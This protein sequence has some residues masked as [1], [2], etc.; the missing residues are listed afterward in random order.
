MS[1]DHPTPADD[2]RPTIHHRTLPPFLAAC[3]RQ[4][5]PYTPVWFMRQAGRY[6]PEYRTLRERY[7][8]LELMRHPDLATHI[9]LLPRALG[10]DALI[11][12]ADILLPL[13]ALGLHLR[14]EPG[15]GPI[16]EP[17]L[18]PDRV[19]TLPQI[20]VHEVLGFVFQTV[21][22]VREAAPEVPLIGFAGAPFTVASY[23]IEGGSSRHYVHT[24]SWMYRH[25]EAWHHLMT[26]LVEVTTTYLRAQVEAGAQAVQIFDSWAGALSPFD[27]RRYVLPYVQ[28]LLQ[29]LADMGVPRIYFSTGTAGLLPLWQ[30]LDAEVIGVDWRV[31]LGTAWDMVGH[32]HAIQGNL[33]PVALFAPREELARQ[34]DQVL[35]QVAGRPGHIFNLG[36]G[37]LPQT[38]P[39]QVAWLAEYVHQKTSTP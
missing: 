37:V 5:T 21:R 33:D 24:K 20:D 12:F 18:T 35:R 7:G 9:T 8:L 23:A 31:P 3:H 4:P 28:R 36:H 6:M 39:A 26:R 14:F 16:L 10:V 29:K 2:R 19:T 30:D 25:P 11:L 38:D 27:Y 1:H 22:Q 13:E 17:R 32:H 15:R 34:A